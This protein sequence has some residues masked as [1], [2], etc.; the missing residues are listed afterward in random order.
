MR[1][2][3]SSSRANLPEARAGAAPSHSQPSHQHHHQETAGAT[4]VMEPVGAAQSQLPQQGQVIDDAG[5][6]RADV[7]GHEVQLPSSNMV[8]TSQ[9]DAAQA[10]DFGAKFIGGGLDAMPGTVTRVQQPTPPTAAAAGETVPVQTLGQQQQQQQ[11]H[12]QTQQYLTAAE[13]PTPTAAVGPSMDYYADKPRRRTEASPQQDHDEAECH[14]FW[15]SWRDVFLGIWLIVTGVL[16][17][18]LVLGDG[19]GKALH[20]TPELYGD[21]T[22]RKWPRLTGFPHGCVAG[23]LVRT[24]ITSFFAFLLYSPPPPPPPKI[25]VWR[26][27][28]LLICPHSIHFRGC[29]TASMMDSRTGSRYPTKQ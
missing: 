20:H 9:F 4:A 1:L 22:V 2:A 23:C 7:V 18:P 14:P 27:A 26:R 5:L 10:I 16:K 17:I 28:W 15:L 12:M 3:K 11:Q 25:Y 24:V 13:Q 19:M 21:K 29:G 8:A 6:T